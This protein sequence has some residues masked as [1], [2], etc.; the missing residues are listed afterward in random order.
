MQDDIL[1]N[2]IIYQDMENIYSR[3]L[4]W[5]SLK[6]SSILVSGATGM[7]AS[8]L[9]YYLI[10]L[11][12]ICDYNIKIKILVRSKEKCR[13]YFGSYLYKSYF[14]VY[15]D[16]LCGT[17]DIDEV[18]YIIH[19][20]SLASPQYYKSSPVEVAAPNAIGT[21]NLLELARKKH[22]RG[23][24]Y[25]SSG[26]VYGKMPHDVGKI[27][28]DVIGVVDPLAIHSCYGESKRMGET[29]CAS[30]AREYNVPAK[31]ARVAHTYSPT[32]DIYNDPRVFASFVRCIVEGR[33][34]VIFS[35]GK[36][37]RPFCYINDALAG[38]F[39]ILLEG[40]SGEAYNVCNDEAFASISELA[41]TL[42]SLGNLIGV[43]YKDRRK[44]NEY[45]ENCDN[46]AN[47]PSA[48]KLKKMGWQCQF[49]I[50]TGFKRVL[51]CI[52]EKG[53]YGDEK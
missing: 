33:D 17:F 26:D 12:E 22:V 11:N 39:L 1:K 8:Y 42:A 15:T 48:D 24:L 36:A 6:N 21:Y 32:M 29:W 43:T 10:W 23:F 16:D 30:F 47:L 18:D 41:D 46:K 37:K 52:K 25:L 3:S 31:I 38:F 35:D 20:A 28:E 34:I 2:K 49:D 7:L 27:D 19:A 9:V 13:K 51:D 44:E 4:E 5:T 40:R 50:R 14:F 45:V 53:V